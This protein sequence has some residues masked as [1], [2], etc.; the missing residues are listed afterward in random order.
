MKEVTK[1]VPV[2]V[3]ITKRNSVNG[4]FMMSG[5]AEI[6]IYRHNC[7]IRVSKRTGLQ[8]T[9][10]VQGG[11]KEV[12]KERSMSIRITG[13]MCGKVYCLCERLIIEKFKVWMPARSV[14]L[15]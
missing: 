5:R 10:G 15:Q 14:A 11:G 13:E 7:M 1:R 2:S 8:H 6:D 4:R 12:I 3:L 9:T